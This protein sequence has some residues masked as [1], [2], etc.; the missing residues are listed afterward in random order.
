MDSHVIGM[1]STPVRQPEVNAVSVVGAPCSSAA[2]IPSPQVGD[3]SIIFVTSHSENLAIE[4]CSE[5]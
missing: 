1:S 3:I 2:E 4:F 5:S